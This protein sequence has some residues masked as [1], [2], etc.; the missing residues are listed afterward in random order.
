MDVSYLGTYRGRNISIIV[1]Y[2]KSIPIVAMYETMNESSAYLRGER[3][4]E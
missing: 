4:S 2:L 1:S 3:I